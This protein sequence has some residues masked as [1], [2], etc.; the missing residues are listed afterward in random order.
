MGF[1][2]RRHEPEGLAGNTA[3][4][5][6]PARRR[7]ITWLPLHAQ[8]AASNRIKCGVSRSTNAELVTKAR[9]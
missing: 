8:D 3:Y 1:R 2:W 4:E 7:K 5:D 9:R 6:S